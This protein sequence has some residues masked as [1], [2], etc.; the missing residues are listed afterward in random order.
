MKKI[1]LILALI[2]ISSSLYSDWAKITSAPNSYFNDVFINGSTVYAV[3]QNSGVHKSTNSTVSWQQLNNGLSNAQA[4]QCKGIIQSG[5]DLY[6]ATVDGIYK[7]TDFAA[8][9]VKKSDGILQ[10][11]G[12]IYL[13]CESIYEL[14]GT[15]YTGAYSG[16]YRSTNGGESWLTTNIAA[17]MHVWA[18]NFTLHNGIIFAARESGNSPNGY[19]STDN[20]LTWQSITPFPYPT[21]T[22]FSEGTK[23]FAGTIHGAWLSTNNGVN[24]IHRAAGLSADPYNSGFLRINGLL[25]TSLKFGGSG[26]YKSSNDGVLWEDFG[27]GLPFLTSIEKIIVFNNKI[28]A[29]T[30]AGIYERNISELTGVNQISAKVPERFSLG[31]NYPNP[32][33]PATSISFSLPASEFVILKIYDALGR[34]VKD[35]ISENLNPGIYEVN[36]DAGALQSG[37][38]F[39]RLNAGKDSE[40]KR[41]ILVK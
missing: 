33:N 29:A 30:S 38:Y 26:M 1:I 2:I 21:I 31:Q 4:V 37:V 22:F 5:N 17:G 7:S 40:T 20:G 25:V 14:N 15:L 41:M 27:Q 32:F 12:A 34:A 9:W 8:S 18:K 19:K 10:G 28:L 35:L 6:A 36:V 13:F 23:I 3:S 11:S 24:W 16:I 39:Y